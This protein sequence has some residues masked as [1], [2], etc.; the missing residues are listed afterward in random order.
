[1]SYKFLTYNSQNPVFMSYKFYFIAH[2][3]QKELLEMFSCLHEFCF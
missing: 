2:E 3:K 1:M